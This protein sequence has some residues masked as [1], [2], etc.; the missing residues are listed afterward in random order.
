MKRP[1]YLLVLLATTTCISP[2]ALCGCSP[3][4]GTMTVYGTVTRGTTPV[5]GM[6]VA[7]F[8]SSRGCSGTNE[9]VTGTPRTVTNAMG[10]Y[11][12]FFG[13]P[14]MS[15]TSCVTVTAIDIQ[16]TRVDSTTVV[17]HPVRLRNGTGEKYYVDS[18]QV[19]IALPVP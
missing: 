4:L 8:A 18:M 12:Q 17:R 7:T 2:T 1:V 6:T 16:P 5:V 9:I 10:Q 19:N 13:I 11:R 15:D 3:T 14:S